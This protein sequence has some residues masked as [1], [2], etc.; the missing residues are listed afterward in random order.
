VEIIITAITVGVIII[1][2]VIAIVTIILN[3]KEENISVS[4]KPI[5]SIILTFLKTK[6]VIKPRIIVII[7]YLIA[8]LLT[9]I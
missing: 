8:L 5:I 6:P 1:T 7:T 2:A 9:P 3:I 4:I